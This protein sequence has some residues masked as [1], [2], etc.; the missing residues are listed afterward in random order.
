MSHYRRIF[1]GLLLLWPLPGRA[2]EANLILKNGRV[3]TADPANPWAEAIAIRG[4][5]ILAAGGNQ[6][7]AALAGPNAQVI[8]LGGRLTIPGF[9]DAHVH[10]LSGS[11]RLGELDLDGACSAVEIQ[12]RLQ[13]FGAAHPND[14]WIIGFGWEHSCFSGGALPSRED[15]DAAVKDRP[16]FLGSSDD[17]AACVNTRA[18]Q[19]AGITNRTKVA[20]AGQIAI[21]AKT[22]EPSGCLTD[23]AIGLVRRIIPDGGHEK[24]IAALEQGLKLAASLGITSFEDGGGDA[25]TVSLFDDLARQHKLTAR[26]EIAMAMMPQTNPEAIDHF[27]DLKEEYHNSLLHVGS[28]DFV[29][30]GTVE[31][32]SA[33]LLEPYSDLPG[34]AGHLAWSSEAFGTLVS[35]CDSVGLQVIAEAHGDRAVRMAIDAYENARKVNGIHDS[36][37]RIERTELVASADLPRLARLGVIAPVRPIPVDA[38]ALDRWNKAVGAQRLNYSFPWRSLRQAGVRLAFSSDWPATTLDPI[39]GI[40]NTVTRETTD[41]KPVGG[42]TPEQRISVDT[43]LRAYT[44]NGAYASFEERQKGELKAGR[45]AD[46][47]VLSQNL[48]TADLANLWKAKVDITIFDGKAIFNRQ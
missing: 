32:H 1:L 17:R 45:L 16:V 23:S 24:K 22:G 40:Y 27:L 41:G 9:N 37:F 28:V 48:F 44:I 6:E 43:A 20:G 33:S 34:N 21:D 5:R 39:R 14:P 38:G 30:D 36:R 31:S 47:V 10:F 46:I 29:L 7:V 8:D 3:W 11:L 42:W 19:L 4:N 25:E 15:L 26:V 35:L 2:A 18:L 12:K 13:Q